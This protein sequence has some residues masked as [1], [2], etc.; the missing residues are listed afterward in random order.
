M[1]AKRSR[2]ST[3]SSRVSRRRTMTWVHGV[4]MPPARY[5]RIR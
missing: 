2:S 3:W 4:F 1:V 5:C